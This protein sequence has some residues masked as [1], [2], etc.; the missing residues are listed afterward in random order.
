[1]RTAIDINTYLL[2]SSLRAKKEQSSTSSDSKLP[3]ILSINRSPVLIVWNAIDDLLGFC[4]RL[5]QSLVGWLLQLHL[6]IFTK[7]KCCLPLLLLCFILLNREESFEKSP[8]LIMWHLN[9]RHVICGCFAMIRGK[10]FNFLGEILRFDWGE[11]LRQI[12]G[13]GQWH[14]I[15]LEISSCQPH[16]HCFAGLNW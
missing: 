11:H 12:N 13:V 15:C 5:Q 16:L 14:I 4:H 2:K 1:M 8:E 9:E 10:L 7:V 6:E 3:P